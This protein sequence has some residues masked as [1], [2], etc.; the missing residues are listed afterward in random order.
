MGP[1]GRGSEPVTPATN[2]LPARQREATV[3]L[4]VGAGLVGVVVLAGVYFAVRPTQ[5]AVD[6]WFLSWVDGSNSRWFNDVTWLRFPVVIVVGSLAAAAAAYPRDRLRSASAW[7]GLRARPA[8]RV[9][10][11]VSSPT[12]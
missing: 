8:A 2:R 11:R 9:I 1:E 10:I 12:S 3:E 5:G 4:V 6:N 7:S